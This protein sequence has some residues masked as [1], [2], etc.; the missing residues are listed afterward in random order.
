MC[1]DDDQCKKGMDNC[2]IDAMC[3]NIMGDYLCVC[4]SGY[5]GNGTYCTDKDECASGTDVCP[6]H[7]NCKNNA[8]S[9]LCKSNNGFSGEYDSANIL[10]CYDVD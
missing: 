4:N 10:K 2:S 8:G 7:S 9:Y 3:I 6:L 1:R 5:V